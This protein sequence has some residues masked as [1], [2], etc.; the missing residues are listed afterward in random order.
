METMNKMDKVNQLTN[1]LLDS[2]KMISDKLPWNNWNSTV[3]DSESN[4]ARWI[5]KIFS[6]G[7]FALLL[8]ILYAVI[9]PL[10]ADATPYA[11]SYQNGFF[12]D[13]QYNGETGEDEWGMKSFMTIIGLLLGT[14]LWAYAAF[15]I[16]QVVRN[17][18]NS[19]A[20]SKSNI[21]NLIFLDVPVALIKLAGYLLAMIALFSALGGLIEFL[22][23]L[24]LGGANIAD[25]TSGLTE[26]ASMGTE[27][28]FSVLND[29][30]LNVLGSTMAEMLN[31]DLS[32]FG[33]G[34]AWTVA[35]ATG[36][37]FSFVSI[38]IILINLYVNVVIYQFIFGL[39]ATLVKWV[40]APYLPFKS[41]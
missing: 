31:P 9:S 41:L 21:I 12:F 35:G 33:I 27:A 11:D 22:T 16:S 14:L 8:G 32:E 29:T 15:P 18:G 19:I 23:T 28:L 24:N 17:I 30:P 4:I 36:V 37:F 34:A 2:P 13:I 40:K 6:I 39:A 20:Q 38:L 26:A 5:G 25:M 10:W 3:E 1:Q 7:A